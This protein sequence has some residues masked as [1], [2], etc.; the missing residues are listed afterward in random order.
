MK[1]T[2]RAIA[3]FFIGLGQLFSLYPGDRSVRIAKIR[4]E[5]KNLQ[6]RNDWSMIHG[7]FCAVGREI[8]AKARR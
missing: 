1:K 7:D 8:I 2:K 3:Y 6:S 5:K 4:R